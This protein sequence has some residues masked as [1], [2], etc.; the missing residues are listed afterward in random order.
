[1]SFKEMFGGTYEIKRK[2]K[3]CEHETLIRIPR[4]TK[5][6][7]HISMHKA[8]CVNCGC[9]IEEEKVYAEESTI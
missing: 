7:D 3:N 5:I 1:M 9:S 4:G 6:K 2:C 8:K